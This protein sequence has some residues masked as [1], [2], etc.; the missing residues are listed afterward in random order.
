M[1]NEVLEHD[2]SKLTS[3]VEVIGYTEHWVHKNPDGKA[4][5]L[6]LQHHY[7][8]NK[9]H[10]QYWVNAEGQQKGTKLE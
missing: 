7:D 6:A 1:F 9:H 5:K 2:N 3:F 10:P 8:S 4:W